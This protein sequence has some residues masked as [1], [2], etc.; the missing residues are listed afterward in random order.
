MPL[1]IKYVLRMDE[2]LHQFAQHPHKLTSARKHR[3]QDDKEKVYPQSAEVCRAKRYHELG[4]LRAQN[5]QASMT[6]ALL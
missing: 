2:P 1:G 5:A 4:A 3:Q 6:E